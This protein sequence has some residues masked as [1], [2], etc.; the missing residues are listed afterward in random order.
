MK[1]LIWAAVGIGVVAIAAM[2]I[3]QWQSN[4]V[5]PTETTASPTET[6]APT[7]NP[8]PSNPPPRVNPPKPVTVNH[9]VAKAAVEPVRAP[10]EPTTMPANQ[11]ATTTKPAFSP[12]LNQA[13]QTL[14]SPQ[15][16]GAQKQAAW[17]Q[18]RE[19]GKMDQAITELEHRSG[20]DPSDAETLAVLGQAYL[21]KAS[22]IQDMREQGLLGLKADMTLEAALKVDPKNWEARYVR[23][24]AMAQWPPQL[25]KSEEVME[26]LV[27]LV[28]QQEAQSSQPHFAATYALLGDQYV[29]AGRAD[30]ARETWQRGASLYPSDPA[31][32]QKLAAQP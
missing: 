25:N 9:P 17:K 7:M 22:T 13:L 11:P 15:A 20:E 23:A 32:Q 5:A 12:A 30:L 10:M 3:M 14:L 24:Y 8:P 1:K 2:A 31:L 28:E 29:K 4:P 16:D 19:S 18:L 21:H 6:P 27:T 26:S